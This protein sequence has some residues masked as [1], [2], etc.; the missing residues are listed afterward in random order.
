[1]ILRRITEHVKTQNWFAVGIDFLIV[2]IGVFIGIQ[3]SNWNENRALDRQSDL[4]SE[5]LIA[6]L[7]EEAW[8]Y[9]F[10]IEY[11]DDVL[12]HAGI[13]LAILEGRQSASDEELLISAYRATQF[14]EAYRRRATF[15]ELTS[16]GNMGLIH[17]PELR[18]TAVRVYTAPFFEN[19]SDE[20]MNSRYREAFRMVVPIDV[21][22]AL[23]EKC[24][25]KIVDIGD[26]DAIKDSIDYECSSGLSVQALA[27][28]ANSLRSNEMLVG[29][30]RLRITNINTVL[31]TMVS[32]NP[33]ITSG[34]ESVTG[35]KL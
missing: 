29:L 19:L 35:V 4:F 14:N 21:Q 27:E 33:E 2:V 10:I 17:D 16:T 3:V 28:A 20:G 1:M 13:A 18:L 8:G 30:L 5:R 22:N 32:S 31:S 24:G 15:D 25:D 9:K 12:K 6:D 34:L 26:F 7:R 11:Y 23:T